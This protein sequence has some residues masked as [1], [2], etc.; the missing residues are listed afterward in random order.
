MKVKVFIKNQEGK[1]EFTE[2]E[3]RELLDEIYNEGYW[4]GTKKYV[5]TTP[6]TTPY[7]TRYNA[8]HPYTVTTIS[9]DLKSTCEFEG[10]QIN[11]IN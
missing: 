1:I 9:N 8:N 11:E 5:Y 4:D 6:Y 3:L 7:I 10:E 2:D